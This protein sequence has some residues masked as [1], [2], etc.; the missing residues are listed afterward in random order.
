MYKNFI[1]GNYAVA[2]VIEALLIVALV[3]IIIS[4]I[5]LVYVPQMMSEREADHMDE[6]EN[7][8][9]FLKSIIDLQRMTKEDVPIVSPVTLGNDALPYLVSAGAN[10]E[11]Q[12]IDGTDYEI[13]VDFGSAI[14]PLTSIKFTAFN[15]Y[16]LNGA[17]LVFSL[18]GGALILN[19][20]VG[21]TIIVEPSI[22]TII[23]NKI[24][25]Y[26]DIPIIIGFSGKKT[27]PRS[28]DIV[29]IRTN[30]SH[31]DNDYISWTN[32]NSIKITTDHPTAWY[33]LTQEVL[34]DNVNY[35][36]DENFVEIT[37]K[38]YPINFYYKRIFIYAQ[39]GPGWIK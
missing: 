20:T 5:Q 6:V 12:I 36:L 32:V 18:E 17:D 9:S 28:S 13:N 1:K 23:T 10:G 29:Y 38:V 16:Y 34:G 7:Q 33:D 8:F 27:S 3:A 30:Y 35:N 37:D 15:V 39:I 22:K 26:Y 24:D 14:I 2:G 4:T 21:E 25:I 11:L 19:Q 31:S